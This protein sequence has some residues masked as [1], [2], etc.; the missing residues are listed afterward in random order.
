MFRAMFKRR[1]PSKEKLPE[2]KENPVEVETPDEDIPVQPFQAEDAPLDELGAV[3]AAEGGDPG[4][5]SAS[6]YKQVEATQ[7]PETGSLS[8]S[9]LFAETEHD[10]ES[11]IGALLELVPETT[12]QEL[13]D[14]LEEIK[15]MLHRW[16]P[17]Q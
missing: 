8:L 3:P 4:A 16:L 10:D 6:I 2:K 15:A 1:E 13:L 17:Q 14:D 7:G 11:G 9:S 5:R 12:V